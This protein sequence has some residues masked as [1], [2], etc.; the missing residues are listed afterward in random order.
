[1]LSFDKELKA[2]NHFIRA[3]TSDIG[4]DEHFVD[5]HREYQGDACGKSDG[6]GLLEEAEYYGDEDPEDSLVTEMSDELHDG[7]EN[8]VSYVFLKE[9]QKLSVPGHV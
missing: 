8:I 4:L 1:M 9:E 2:V 7:S 6:S 3:D 5:K